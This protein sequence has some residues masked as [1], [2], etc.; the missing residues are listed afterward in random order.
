MLAL[1]SSIPDGMNL[2]LE[3]KSDDVIETNFEIVVF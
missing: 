1:K 3:Y 2:A